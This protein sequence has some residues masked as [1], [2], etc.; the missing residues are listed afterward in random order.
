[1]DTQVRCLLLRRSDSTQV[2]ASLPQESVLFSP[3]FPRFV[4]FPV[5]AKRRQ[6]SSSAYLHE[7]LSCCFLR[8]SRKPAD[9]PVSNSPQDKAGEEESERALFTSKESFFYSREVAV[10]GKSFRLLGR[11]SR[12]FFPSFLSPSGQEAERCSITRDLP[13]KGSTR[14]RYGVRA[15]PTDDIPCGAPC[16]DFLAV[17][18]FCEDF[19][20]KLSSSSSADLRQPFQIGSGDRL[21]DKEEQ[22]LLCFHSSVVGSSLSPGRRFASA[23][24]LTAPATPRIARALHEPR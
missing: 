21:A 11:K 3:L 1:M 23:C 22:S 18:S 20:L 8:T 2:R 6:T 5:K 19:A 16:R 9:G 4:A 14:R 13:C 24:A 17:S 7:G 10:H 12:L 15:A